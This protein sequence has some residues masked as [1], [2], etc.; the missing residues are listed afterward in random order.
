MSAATTM[1]GT[2]YVLGHSDEELNRL[3]A[4]SRFFNLLSAPFLETA[5][6]SAG[7][8]ALDIGCGAG[9]MAFLA[10]N[11]V[12]PEGT[13][14]SVDSAPEAVAVATERAAEA[15]LTN[16][17][18]L[19]QDARELTLDEPVDAIIGRLVLMYFADPA[20]VLRRLIASLRL[21]G[22][23]AFHEIDM[24]GATSHPYRH[25]FETAVERIR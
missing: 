7:M 12:G 5:G 3:I 25:L 11:L 14:I 10:A 23:V 15:G 22:I 18:F 19:T 16:V 13:V 24:V 6:L 2:Q 17:R 9:D 4:Q 1:E 8:R 21:G 20:V